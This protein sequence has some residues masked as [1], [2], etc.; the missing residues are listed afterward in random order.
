MLV[1]GELPPLQVKRL[2]ENI[3]RASRQIQD[4]LQELSDVTT[5]RTDPPEICSLRDIVLAA[6]EPLRG[7][8]E[9][10]NIDL[11]IDVPEDVELPLARARMERVF[12]NLVVNSIEAIDGAGRIE[13]AA[14]RNNGAV[15]VDITDSG[16]GIPAS[17]GSRLFQP[18]ASEGKRNGV[19][20]GLASS[21]QTVLNHGGD[22]WL[23][24]NTP[25][26]AHFRMRLV[27]NA[28]AI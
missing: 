17:I 2:S 13:I 28:S 26:G 12:T 6:C 1:D 21:R 24:P 11:E 20:L 9:A 23:V 4:L 19:G 10:Q 27:S 18:F 16:P 22:L 7:Q 14:R 3:Y 8:A 5:G 15:Y 25:G